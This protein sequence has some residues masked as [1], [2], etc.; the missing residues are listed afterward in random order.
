MKNKR[1]S[2]KD[3]AA[4]LNISVTTVSFVLNGK[5]EKHRISEKLKQK[6][7]KHAEKI[8]YKPNQV[9]QSLRTGKSKIIV[10]MVQDISNIFFAQIARIL[11][12]LAYDRGYKVLFCSNENNDQRSAELIT[13]FMER[14]VDG[15]IITPS[16]GIQKEIQ[17]L[18]AQEIPVLLFDRYFPQLETSYV[19]IDNFHAAESATKHLIKNGFRNVA[20]ITT[21]VKQT[22]VNDRLD[23]YAHAM[24]ENKLD[25]RVLKIR[26]A[27]NTVSTQE[28]L[29]NYFGQNPDIDAVF[30][31][32]NYLTKAGLIVLK[33][34]Y[35]D[36]IQ[37]LGLISFDENEYYTIHTPSITSISQPIAKIGKNLID[38][39]MNLIE[40]NRKTNF[41]KVILKARLI[42]RESS[43][44]K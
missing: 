37:K 14:D 31:S 44:K 11:E 33:K 5:A 26:P 34:D 3:I 9:A 22:Q 38:I 39:M 21:N 2:I 12:D 24:K 40:T 10:F 28:K 42:R 8:G 20:F 7:I 13:L 41:K 36:L 15:F 6:I 30:F 23:G 1:P 4:Q 16:P 29:S 27:K 25:I 18:Q 43:M 35:P 17:R 32:N 19:G